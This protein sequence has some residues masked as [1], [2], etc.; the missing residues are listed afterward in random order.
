MFRSNHNKRLI[1]I[2]GPTA[3]GKTELAIKLAERLNG[4]IVSAD[5]RL[6][7]QGMD[8][9]TAK[10]G[11]ADLS[12]VRHYLIDSVPP[13]ETW[14]L[15][16]FQKKASE[17]IDE[18]LSHG[19]QPFLVG[20]TGQYVRAVIE[21]WEMPTQ[22]PDPRLRNVLEAWAHDVGPIALHD[23][24]ELLDQEAAG[25]IDP[26]N[27]RRTI[28]AL[29]VIFW[30]GRLFSKQRRI[31]TCPYSYLMIGLSRPRSEL[32]ARID[33]RIDD[34]IKNGL[35]EE[36]RKL[37]EKGYDPDL[38]ALS[39]IGYHEIIQY[40]QG[41]ISLEEAV[42]L[43]KRK[44]RNFV[45]RQANWFKPED[46]NIHWFTMRENTIDEIEKFILSGEGWISPGGE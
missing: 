31:R 35:V 37:L 32:Y 7:Y 4:E 42:I 19:R 22:P 20:G 46:P 6:F 3:V 5:S 18:I 44:T 34:M 14:S 2:V 27:V 26:N 13:A 39:A 28:R 16:I 9:G 41:E 36:T 40:I 21:G 24:L 12:R 29:E 33:Q 10:P 38:P 1:V 17:A 30:T 45:R 11:R 23:K 25:I 8:I 43:I 15:A